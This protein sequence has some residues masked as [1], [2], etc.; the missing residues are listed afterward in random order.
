[1]P[2]KF[3]KLLDLFNAG[4]ITGAQAVQHEINNMIPLLV[5]YGDK[6]CIKEILVMQGFPCGDCRRPF[7]PLSDSARKEIKTVCDANSIV[8]NSDQ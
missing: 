4:D 7:K 6:Q 3:R 2:D 8:N 5:K 1:M